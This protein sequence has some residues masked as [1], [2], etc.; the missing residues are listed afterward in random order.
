[1]KILLSVFML[2]GVFR[3]IKKNISICL[4]YIET[5]GLKKL[6][7]RTFATV[8]RTIHLEVKEKIAT[9]KKWHRKSWIQ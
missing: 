1:M 2:K 8:V 6:Q 4:L 5:I 9:L 7:E 3:R